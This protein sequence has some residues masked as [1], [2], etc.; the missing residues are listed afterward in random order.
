M[1]STVY[2]HLRQAN[3]DQVF[4]VSWKCCTGENVRKHFHLYNT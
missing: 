2:F 3:I 4:P 1:E